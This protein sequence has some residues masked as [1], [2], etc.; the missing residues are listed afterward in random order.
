M[1]YTIF[2]FICLG[3]FL[4]CLASSIA[5]PALGLQ[6]TISIIVILYYIYYF[7][8][9]LLLHCFAPYPVGFSHMEAPLFFLCHLLL[10]ED[11]YCRHLGMVMKGSLLG[12]PPPH[13]PGEKLC[14]W[15]QTRPSLT[16]GLIWFKSVMSL[17]E[18]RAHPPRTAVWGMGNSTLE[19]MAR[20]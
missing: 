14:S 11:G 19:N 2:S 15:A 7:V 1:S 10:V 8:G 9:H 16:V 12:L 6:L 17:M 13:I 5:L 4:D 18:R 3:L 20:N